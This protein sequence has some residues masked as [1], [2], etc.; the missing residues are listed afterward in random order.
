MLRGLVIADVIQ[1]PLLRG[2]WL[3]PPAR[4][5]ALRHDT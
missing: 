4:L 1:I 5:S 2:D 3:R